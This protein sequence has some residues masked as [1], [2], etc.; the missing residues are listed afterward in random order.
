MRTA[1][2]DTNVV[3]DYAVKREGF[4]EDAKKVFMQIVQ[5]SFVGFVS[6]SAVTDIY[7]F[8]KKHYKSPEIALSQ[9]ITFLDTLEVLTVDRQTI[10]AA[11]DSGMKDFEDA[12]QAAT[13]RDFGIDIVVTRDKTGFGDSGLQVCSPEEFL[14]TLN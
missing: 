6:S 14:E 3:L 2:I 11:I 9:L 8:L 5:G 13:A 10:E 1:L 4:F 7:F 12:V